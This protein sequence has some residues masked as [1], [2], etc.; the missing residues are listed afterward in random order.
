MS[1]IAIIFLML[2]SPVVALA[3][4]TLGPK[5]M[6]KNL[7][8]EE[9]WNWQQPGPW[10]NAADSVVKLDAESMRRVFPKAL[11]GCG[12]LVPLCGIDK[13]NLGE[14]V[15]KPVLELVQSVPLE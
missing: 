3:G 8:A 13:T 5:S 4:L 12:R 11:H 14:L 9:G 6:A 2:L 15:V 10:F 1:R 7:W